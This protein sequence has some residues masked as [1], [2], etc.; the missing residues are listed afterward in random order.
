[1]TI[2]AAQNEGKHA[3]EFIVS[4]YDPNYAVETG[5]LSSGQKAVDG[6]LL[7]ITGGELVAKNATLNTAG[8][9]T[10]PI[11]GIVIGNWDA[12]ATGTNADIPDV[13]YIKRGPLVVKDAAITYPSTPTKDE[14]QR[15]LRLMLIIPR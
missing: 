13:P 7:Q 15:D 12:S 1:M 4:D 6:Q 11:E 14:A 9:F 10:T 8:A 5:T 3:G 2:Y